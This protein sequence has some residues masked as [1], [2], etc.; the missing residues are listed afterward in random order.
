MNALLSRFSSNVLLRC[1]KILPKSDYKKIPVVILLQVLLALIDLIAVAI[2]G[3]IAAISI[4][5]IQST[6]PNYRITDLLKFFGLGE[7]SL[8]N[9]VSILGLVAAALLISRTIASVFITRKTLMFLSRRGAYI[10][11]EVFSKLTSQSLIKLRSNSS[12][13]F[14]ESLFGSIDNAEKS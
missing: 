10:A 8:Q 1:L 14:K 11:S 9:Q 5:G 13:K 4:G 3:V 7:L 6:A 2:V 12:A